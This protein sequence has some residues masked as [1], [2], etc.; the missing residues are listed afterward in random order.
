MKKLLGA[1]LLVLSI[2]LCA[3]T[4]IPQGANWLYLDDGSN[5]GTAWRE[6]G[7]DDSS[8]DNGDAQL[9]YG[10]GD[11]VTV[12]SYGPS[13]SNKYA[14]TYFR[15]HFTVTNLDDIVRFKLN[16]LRDDGAIIYLNGTEIRRDNM[17][18]SGVTYTTYASST[19]SGSAEDTFYETFVEKDYFVEGEN[20]IA[21]EI[22]QRSGS[23]S[24]ISFDMKL[25]TTDEAP[26]LF[27]KLPYLVYTREMKHRVLWQLSLEENSTLKWGTT[28]SCDENEI[29]L[30]PY[31]DKFQTKYTFE[32][33]T[34]NT[35]YY[36]QVI[37]GE[38]VL[39]GDFYS[40]P[41]Q[42]AENLTFY[43]Y[44]DTR[45]YPEDHNIVAQQM[46]NQIT[47]DPESQTLLIS[48]GDLVS[49]GDSEQDWDMEF[50]NKDYPSIIEMLSRLPYQSA[51]GNHEESAVLYRDYFPYDY[52]TSGCYYSFDFG[53]AH[54]AIVDQYVSYY[55]GNPQYEWLEND[56]SSTDKPWKFVYLHEPGWAAGG[57][58]NN[59]L[60]Q[61]YI[62][63]LCEQYDVAI[64]FAGHN[65][66][67][68]RA[69]VDDIQ[70]VTTGGGGA[71]LY[72]PN[73]SMPNIVAA[74]EKHHFCKIEINDQVLN[75]KA[76]D[77]YG[78]IF[79][80]F[81]IDNTNSIDE[82]NVISSVELFDNYPNPF[83]PS[84]K[85]KFSLTEKSHVELSVFNHKGELVNTLI[86]GEKQPETH[87]VEWYGVDSKNSVV[88]SGV[89]FYRL[90]TNN[91]SITKK[92]MLIK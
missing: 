42:D 24:D 57:H 88:P 76:I 80:T 89:Y 54:F 39:S 52:E 7:F 32:N 68:S 67:Y 9:G 91:S 25:E 61:N 11:E 21:V 65:H 1:I 43:A 85:I 58:N 14:T 90:K 51:R 37:A 71:P 16:L 81:E 31:N 72:A 19:V 6:V 18:A 38:E 56:L 83:N 45:T 4:V 50:F 92:M 74:E 28:P 20:V 41:E 49:D 47:A 33:L 77:K 60:V 87:I 59:A 5:Q 15:H 22:H 70:H 35:K 26:D 44:G 66:Y 78:T 64:L 2:S 55:T 34:P 69:V 46:L 3:E 79:D 75:F 62:Q 53:P 36:Y 48:V 8:W 82:G 17:P 73:P 63:P 10:D 12:L 13:S 23:S 29:E 86:N 30:S 27:R 40:A 84:T